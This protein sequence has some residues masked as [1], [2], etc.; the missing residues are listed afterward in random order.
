MTDGEARGAFLAA[1]DAAQVFLPARER[2]KATCVL[3]LQPARHALQELGRR[4]VDSGFF[5]AVDDFTLLTADELAAL[6]EAPDRWSFLIEERR[7]WMAELNALEPPFV[8]TGRPPLPSTWAPRALRE[9]EPAVAGEV[10]TGVTGCHGQATGI[11]RVINTPADGAD[12]QP[13]EVLVAEATDPG[14]T[15]L[16]VSATAVVVDTG[17]PLSHAAIVSRELGVPCVISAPNASRRIP[18]GARIAVD[19]SAGTVTVLSVP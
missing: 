15:P 3:L 5:A 12:L 17:A 13:G 7:Q 16:F 4:L 10:L 8:F 18:D 14:W 6:I 1:V 9:F 19:G 11:A 2:T